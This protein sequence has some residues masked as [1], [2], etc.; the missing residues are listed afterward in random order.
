[1]LCQ[2]CRQRQANV[3]VTT[4]VEN[5]RR[6]LH[7]CD[8]CASTRGELRFASEAQ[9]SLGEMLAALL[10]KGLIKQASRGGGGEAACP[11]CGL[12][13]DEFTR[14]GKLGCSQCFEAFEE[15]LKGVLRH[16]H[17]SSRHVGRAPKR[18]GGAMRLRREISSLRG[19]L[20]RCVQAEQFEQA[21]KLRDRISSLESQLKAKVA[22]GGAQAGATQQEAEPGLAPE[23]R[24]DAAPV[25]GLQADGKSQPAAGIQPDQADAMPRGAD[26]APD[27]AAPPPADDQAEASGAEPGQGP[28]A[29][30][31]GEE[32]ADDPR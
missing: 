1:M 24:P 4:I 5:Q 15:Q 12:D 13:Y 21:A 32:D 9:A 11:T 28:K 25:A 6:E 26:P 14:H 7:L 27:Q 3:K 23:S 30:R 16:V 19:E 10:H 8:E 18:G 22:A 31:R 17:G 20:T 2:E 29:T